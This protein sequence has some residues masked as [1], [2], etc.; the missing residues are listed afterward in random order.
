MNISVQSRPG[1]DREGK[2]CG[3]VMRCRAANSV[4]RVSRTFI[5]SRFFALVITV[6]FLPASPFLEPRVNHV[7]C[8]PT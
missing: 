3:S 1:V 2:R 8:T 5:L 4:I 7:F 6:R